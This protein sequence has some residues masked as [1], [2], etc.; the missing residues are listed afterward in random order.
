MTTSKVFLFA[1]LAV[2]AVV[3]F[4]SSEI[5]LLEDDLLDDK[6][7][8]GGY[9][10]FA[11]EMP[12]AIERRDGRLRNPLIRFGKRDAETDEDLS[13]TARNDFSLNP[14]IRF[15]KRSSLNSPLIRFG[16]RPDQMPLIRF[17]K[18]APSTAPLIRFGKREVGQEEN[19]F[20]SSFQI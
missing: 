6:R 18:R 20:G 10:G 5:R 3:A 16:K 13:R 7:S 1:V 12:I 19:V 4:E 17:G 8:G 14:L 15:G 9:Y 2:G 11:D